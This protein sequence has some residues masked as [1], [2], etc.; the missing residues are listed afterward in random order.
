ME[1]NANFKALDELVQSLGITEKEVTDW[2]EMFK[3]RKRL[4]LEPFAHTT[5]TEA[6]NETSAIKTP[7]PLVYK[8]GSK[9]EVSYFL[10]LHRRDNVWGYQLPCGVLVNK[11][12]GLFR[13]D[14]AKA[15]AESVTFEDKKGKLPS[16]KSLASDQYAE[17]LAEETIKIL[18][19]NGITADKYRGVI[20]CYDD[21]SF[22][23]H[24]LLLK[25]FIKR[26]SF[27]C[28]ERLAVAF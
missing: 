6:F 9:M 12:I 25:T 3:S 7:L 10:D 21:D 20:W 13:C 5:E 16:K 14:D 1:K 17:F 4:G 26:E 22:C 28:N 11:T 23:R 2:F 18:I 24:N 8:M 27:A 15:F 19:A